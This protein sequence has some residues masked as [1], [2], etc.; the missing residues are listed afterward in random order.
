MIAV[1]VEPG[2]HGDAV[3]GTQGIG[4]STP[5]AAVVAAATV[6]LAGE[7]HIPNDPMLVMGTKSLTF[8]AGSVAET[9]HTAEAERSAFLAT[10]QSYRPVRHLNK[11]LEAWMISSRR[12]LRAFY[13]SAS[14]CSGLKCFVR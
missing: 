13:F 12:S 7:L 11:L 2:T 5:E 6:G 1:F 8:A 3:F 4:V 9:A 10:I 14:T